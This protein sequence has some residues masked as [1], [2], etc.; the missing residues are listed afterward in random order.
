MSEFARRIRREI[1]SAEEA[2][3]SIIA[4][5]D[6]ELERAPSAELW[7]LRG[8]AIQLCDDEEAYDLEEAGASYERAL[9][10]EPNN[11]EAFESL[12]HYTFSV[13]DDP[14]KSVELFRKAISLGAGASAKEGLREAEQELADLH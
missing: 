2:S 13:L 11:A 7:I 4:E 9:E 5:I 6:D 14:A 1:T 12:A 8:D 3:T 10:L